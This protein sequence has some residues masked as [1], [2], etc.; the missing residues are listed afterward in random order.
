MGALLVRE[1]TRRNVVEGIPDAVQIL[2]KGVMV[3][4]SRFLACFVGLRL[5]PNRGFITVAAFATATDFILPMSEPR[6]RN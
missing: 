1:R 3:D 2:V 4:L 5:D 6:K